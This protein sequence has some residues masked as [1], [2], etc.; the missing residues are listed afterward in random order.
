MPPLRN[1]ASAF[2]EF[3]KTLVW[4][5]KLNW[6]LNR[7]YTATFLVTSILLG[8]HGTI[9]AF[10]MAGIID[11][12]LSAANNSRGIEEILPWMAAFGVFEVFYSAVGFMDNHVTRALSFTSEKL[13]RLELSRKV[14]SLDVSQ[15]EDPE[16]QNKIRRAEEQ[17]FA[18]PRYLNDVLTTLMRLA[19]LVSTFFVVLAFEPALVGLL[20]VVTIP[21]MLVDGYFLQKL[22][23]L[24]IEITEQR[25]SAY[26]SLG[27][28]TET[29]A[30]LEL[31][32]SLGVSYLAQKFERFADVWSRRWVD[33]R[34]RWFG[35]SFVSE[36]AP[37]AV[38]IF[39]YA[40]AF[41]RFIEGKLTVGDASFFARSL[42]T[43]GGSI[44][45]IGGRLSQLNESAQRLKEVR[46]LFETQST[47][48]DGGHPLP[49]LSAGPE[50]SFHDVSFKYPR[51]KK[52]VIKELNLTIKSGEKVALV[53]HNGA[54][55]TTLVKLITR[56][57]PATKGA[58]AINGININDLKLTDWYKNIGVLFQEYNTY[59]H[60]T[61]FENIAMGDT[62]Q[63]PSKRRAIL[64]AK[65][66]DAHS[67]IKEYENGYDQV[68]SERFKGGTRPSSGQWQKIATARFFYRNAPLVIFDEPTAA[69]DAV[70]EHKIFNKIYKFF[71]GKTV[72]IISH[73]FSTVRN[74]DRIIVFEKGRVVEEGSHEELMRLG[75]AYHKAF[76]LQ[77][78]GYQARQT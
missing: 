39:G 59:S 17:I 35:Y 11:A 5:L 60:L 57:Y 66:S 47:F 9:S 38:R 27:Y 61:A 37:I 42:D 19:T 26:K 62:H 12:A 8:V 15:H 23:R 34:K 49:K 69:I 63:A 73:R 28:L 20:L 54:G 3:A 4:V 77:A 71:E 1:R 68:L 7:L 70:A 58:I 32:T 6:R 74:T 52:F 10:V 43:F 53:G 51:A 29:G 64:A 13:L 33:I 56:F 2:R 50:V 31:K 22:F 55:K 25:R 24:D 67:F 18:I 76:S 16:I 45:L 36:V 78:K 21:S 72:I 46:E 41:A 75:G 14:Q 48:K 30:L 44:L 40:L 65:R